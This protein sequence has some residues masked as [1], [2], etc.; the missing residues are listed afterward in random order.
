MIEQI[1]SYERYCLDTTTYTGV[2]PV[3]RHGTEAARRRRPRPR[4]PRR[5]DDGDCARAASLAAEGPAHPNLWNPTI[6]GVL[7]VLSAIGLFCGSAYLLLGTNLGARLG[8]LVAAAGLTGFMVLLTH[9]VVDVR[10]TAASTRRTVTRRS[11]RSSRSSTTRRSRRSRGARHREDRQADRTPRR[12]RNLQAR[13]STPRSCT[14]AS[15]RTGR[16]RRAAVR[17]ARI[18]ASIDYLTDFEGFKTF[19]VRRRHQ[20]LLLAQPAVRGGAVLPAATRSTP[21]GR[22]RRATR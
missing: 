9:A 11:G 10:A 15:R 18:S 7:V 12:S 4:R 1:V 20:E 22:R 21:I 14:R 6:L 3:V 5:R 13:R 2:E 16:R 8:F 19:T 17:D